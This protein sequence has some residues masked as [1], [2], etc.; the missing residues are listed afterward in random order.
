MLFYLTDSLI[1]EE[2][3][4]LYKGIYKAVHNLATQ[5]VDGNHLLTASYAAIKHFRNIFRADP[6]IGLFLMI[7]FKILLL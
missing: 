2:N 6:I 3:N 4:P 7:Y 5:V 1:V